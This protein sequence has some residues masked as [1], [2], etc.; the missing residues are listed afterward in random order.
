MR[1]GAK[2]FRKTVTFLK[3]IFLSETD[4][5]N[6]GDV[7]IVDPENKVSKSSYLST[8][9]NKLNLGSV[10]QDTFEIQRAR[11]SSGT[12]VDLDIKAGNGFG[13]DKRGGDLNLYGGAST[14]GV[15]G[16]SI[17]FWQGSRSG[18][19]GSSLN[20]WTEMFNL[21]I[22]QARIN[23]L[24]LHTLYFPDKDAK[25][26]SDQ[27]IEFILDYDNDDTN[28]YLAIKDYTI[29]RA[30]FPDEGNL[31]LMS[32]S[33]T[34]GLF[35]D[36]INSTIS[37]GSKAAHTGEDANTDNT[38]GVNQTGLNLTITGG[39]G[40][41]SG[42]GGGISFGTY[43]GGAAATTVNSTYEEKMAM[44]KDG[45]LQIDGNLTPAGIV[46]DGNTITGVDD[47]GEFTNDDAHIMT[48]A[49]IEDKILGY[50][51]TT[52]TGDIT[53]MAIS[54]GSTTSTVASGDGTFQFFGGE[55]VD[56][57]L[58][59]LSSNFYRLTID[60]EDASTS[61]KGVASFSSDNFAAS[62][63]EITIKSGG[64][65]LTDEVT[66]T[67]PVSN[68]GTGV[69]S[70]GSINISSFNNDSGFTANTGDITSVSLIPDDFSSVQV[71]SGDAAFNIYGGEGIDTSGS[72]GTITI[73][74]ED[75]SDSNKGIVELATTAEADTG[76]DTAR[77]V[78]PAGLKSHVDARFSYQYISFTGSAT[79]PSDG[80]WIT[81]SANGISNHTWNTDL[82]SGGTT[83]GS[84]TVT[85][86]TGAICQGIIV[87]YDCT[88]VGYTSLIR[89]V[90]NHQSKVGL[91]VGV[92]TYNDFA[93]F[94][95]TLRAYNAADISA[96]PDSNY[97]QR[98]V[99]AD[100]L[101][102]N[103]SMS[104]G[105]VIF[106]LIGS[107]A[108]NSRTVQWNCTLVLKTLLP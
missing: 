58:S 37:A 9:K 106:P 6:V 69:T 21:E 61:N 30:L 53:S 97:S 83:V 67:L 88:L 105:H 91:A 71:T 55:G 32:A 73:A 82:G 29:V 56:V 76:T 27:N 7:L 19:S 102:A 46:L 24:G 92:P 51:Y 42:D 89:S 39:A 2:T 104:A 11:T 64:V 34:T 18:S 35:L 98:P 68:G 33:N 41:G 52:N 45:N 43:P 54:D 70:L 108:S 99:R 16:G 107:V 100:Y 22:T 4:R 81:L 65:D 48:S 93:T 96:G 44:D 20:A 101:S 75:A 10:N 95:C 25:I 84:S 63:G 47:S 3:S 31:Y 77:A 28:R 23:F 50:G 26:G 94:D 12:G 14:G 60:G 59:T 8:I 74:G 103:H 17:R 13:T 38:G 78:T 90:G 66:G 15:N 72:A 85:I 79:V 57:S 36:A 87:P 86:P 49:A 1:V 62:S 5:E 80:D 40:T